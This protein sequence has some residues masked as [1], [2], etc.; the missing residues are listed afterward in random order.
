[1]DPAILLLALLKMGICQPVD[2]PGPHEIV[3]RVMVCPM[4]IEKPKD[5]GQPT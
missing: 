3:L 2:F 5:E 1:M 4:V